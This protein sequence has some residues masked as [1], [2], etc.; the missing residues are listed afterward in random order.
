MIGW[1]ESLPLWGTFVVTVGGFLSVTVLLGFVVARFVPQD[2]REQHNELAGFILAVI[3]VIY[4]V[5]LAF[6]TIG[7]W[8]RFESAE[9]RTYEEASNLAI[10]YRDAGSF[11]TGGKVRAALH[12]YV[13]KVIK[14]EWPEMQQG[15]RSIEARQ[16]LEAVDKDV[17]DLPVRT[18]QLQDVHDRML[19]AIDKALE[20]R[21]ERVSM[22]ATGINPVMWV[23][24]FIGAFVTVAFTYL[25]GFKRTM[26][27]QIMVGSLSLLIGLVI[28][29]TIALDYPYRGGL[30]IQPDAFENALWVFSMIGS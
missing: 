11:P 12:D 9:A 19:D 7:V 5:L 15:R 21:D 3:G 26:M 16:M 4:A 28:F 25:F 27:Q 6:V 24:L 29:L 18:P 23:I 17:R 14:D 13:E 10:V 1:F 20:L 8:E 22:D 2:L 30:Q